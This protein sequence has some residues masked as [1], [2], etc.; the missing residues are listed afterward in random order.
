MPLYAQLV[1]FAAGPLAGDLMS[2]L[3]R[4]PAYQSLTVIQVSVITT[5]VLLK[6]LSLGQ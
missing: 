4:I 5:P 2:S 3:P 6:L 1:V